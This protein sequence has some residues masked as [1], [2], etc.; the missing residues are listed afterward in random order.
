MKTANLLTLLRCDLKDFLKSN[1]ELIFNERDLQVRITMWLKETKHYD[2]VDMEYAVPK[3][4]LCVHHLNVGK[5]SLDFPWDNDLSI[6]VVVEKDGRFAAV[7]FKYATC[8]VI[9]QPSRFGED[10]KTG[11]RIIKNQGAGDIIMYNYWKD[12]RRIEAL[13]QCY[14]NMTGGVALLV[15]NNRI[16]WN[17]P[18]TDVSY[19]AFS[20]HE[21]NRIGPGLL[22]W[23]KISENII[24]SHPDFELHGSYLCHWDDTA[25]TAL[26][27]NGDRFRFLLTTIQ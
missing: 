4:E 17:G 23:G 7:E 10:L 13:N 2:R 8:P 18:S 20:T 19:R 24:R 14:P 9:N 11:C 27:K 1:K 21:G 26:T 5:E 25:I 12:V 15:T 16:Y 22:K 6:D 3:E